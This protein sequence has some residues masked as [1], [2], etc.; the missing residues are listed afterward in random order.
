MTPGVTTI[1]AHA[2]INL[3]LRVLGA[4]ADGFHELRT[5]FQSIAL[6]DVIICTA[7]PGPFVIECDAP[8]VPLD[9]T[10]LLTEGKTDV[11]FVLAQLA[12]HPDGTAAQYTAYTTRLQAGATQAWAE[13]T[14][15]FT[16]TR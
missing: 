10:G 6:H 15:T 9:R 1:R 2:K 3:D 14:G 4:R 16:A 7:R 12:Q 11:S 5:V 8:G 13:T